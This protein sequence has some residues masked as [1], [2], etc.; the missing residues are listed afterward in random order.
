MLV[1]TANAKLLENIPPADILPAEFHFQEWVEYVFPFLLDQ[2]PYVALIF[3]E[4][5]IF[6]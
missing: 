5:S 1:G 4:S 2:P 6:R 3:G